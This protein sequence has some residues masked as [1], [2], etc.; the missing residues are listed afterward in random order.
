MWEER[1][2]DSLSCL[3]F[4]D[5]YSVKSMMHRTEFYKYELQSPMY[6]VMVLVGPPNIL[7][8]SPHFRFACVCP[9]LLVLASRPVSPPIEN[10]I[11]WESETPW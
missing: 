7:V 3:F 10:L 9:R 2:Q 8:L 11:V 1:Q 6:Y 5:V 4:V